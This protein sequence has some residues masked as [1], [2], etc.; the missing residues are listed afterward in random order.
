MARVA[1]PRIQII[2]T[3]LAT[4]TFYMVGY[5]INVIM[6]IVL[7]SEMIVRDMKAR[8]FM[9]LALLFRPK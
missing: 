4:H 5:N 8:I 1:T 3:E 7:A 6:D 9:E 2:Q